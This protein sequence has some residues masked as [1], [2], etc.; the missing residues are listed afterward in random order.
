MYEQGIA[1][2][3]YSIST[4]AEYGDLT[5][6][7]RIINEAVRAEMRRVLDEI[8]DGRFAAEW[9]AENKAG[10]PNFNRLR[11]EGRAHPI[12]QIGAELRK[13]MPFINQGRERF[14][15]VSGG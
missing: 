11:E 2:M 15:D 9:I 4:T 13:M 6:G 12:E 14:E 8:Q 10:L 3:R 7:P 1:G 5:R